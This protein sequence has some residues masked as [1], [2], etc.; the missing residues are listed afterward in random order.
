MKDEI[1]TKETLIHVPV[2]DLFAWHARNGAINR[3]TP[4]WSKLCLISRQGN[5]IDKGVK[6]KFKIKV[7]GIP[8]IWEAAH[9]E[10]LENK[11]FRDCQKRGPFALWEHTHLFSAKGKNAALMEDRI[12]FRLPM[13]FLSRPFYGHARRELERIFAYRHRV[14]KDDMENR[15]GR[16][17]KQRILVSGA[18]G[19]IGKALV[20]FLRTCG[21]EVIRLVRDPKDKSEDA[22]YWDPYNNI[23]DMDA[24][25]P[26][27]AVISLNGT[28]ISR[29]RWTPAQRKLIVDSRVIPTRVLVEKMRTMARPPSVFISSSAIGFYGEG[30]EKILTEESPQGDSFISRVCDQWETASLGAA[31]AGIR[32]VQLRIG[33]VLTPGGGA[34]KRMLLPFSLG[35]GT[36]ISQGRQYMSWISMDDALGGILHILEKKQ[37]H[38]PVNLTAPAPVTNKVFTKTL[39][40]IFSRPAM[41]VLPR[42]LAVFLWGQMGKETLLTS[43][44]VVPQILVDTGYDFSHPVLASALAHVLGRPLKN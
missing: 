43:A 17:R 39:G 28:D 42:P 15:A 13:G 18:S 6:V 32:T 25:G 34:L 23:L 14:L 33:V 8:M 44:R 41:F 24:A 38:G 5:G 40:N 30:G 26:V 3:L 29:G 27:D 10:Y 20:P 1:F 31:R 19:T 2:E 36:R 12:R 7:M 4:P 16:I 11:L 22:L 9:V 21:H 37:I 35:L